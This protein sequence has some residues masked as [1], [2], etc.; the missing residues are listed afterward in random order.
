MENEVINESLMPFNTCFGCGQDNPHSL[1]LK[2]YRDT[3]TKDQ[4]LGSFKP[5]KDQIGFPGITHGGII[6]TALDCMAAWV[7]T[8]LRRD[9]KAIWILRSAT[10]TYHRPAY[11]SGTLHLRAHIKQ[12]GNSG[13]SMVIHAEA[14][15]TDNQLL[16]EG[17]FK[18]IPL[19]AQ[20]FMKVAG[21]KQIPENL[22]RIFD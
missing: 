8:A 17:D 3:K 21:L 10:M 11:E 13:E 22:N 12:E 14:A 6:Y 18:V 5:S 9:I 19:S 4:L 15:N 16:A 1:Q 2:V 7:P 20:K